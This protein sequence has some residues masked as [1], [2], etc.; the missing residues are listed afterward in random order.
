MPNLTLATTKSGTD[1]ALYRDG[2]QVFATDEVNQSIVEGVLEGIGMEF[3][4]VVIS[5]G[6]LDQDGYMPSQIGKGTKPD[7]QLKLFAEMV[8]A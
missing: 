4:R 8:A 1:I 7:G 2:F 3:H 6:A 5:D